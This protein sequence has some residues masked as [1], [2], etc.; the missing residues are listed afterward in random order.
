LFY[1]FFVRYWLEHLRL[2]SP[3]ASV[4]IVGTHS[5]VLDNRVTAA[6]EKKLRDFLP[7]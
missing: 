1:I 6:Q 2:S 7:L 5:D 4:V 3:R